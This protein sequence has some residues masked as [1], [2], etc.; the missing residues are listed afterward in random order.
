MQLNI[1][2]GQHSN[3]SVQPLDTINNNPITLP[4]DAT[5]LFTSSDANMLDIVDNADHQTVV[6]SAITAGDVTITAVMTLANGTSFTSTLSVVVAPVVV[7]PQIG[8]IEI[9][10]STPF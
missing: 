9:V 6:A 2:V 8:S 5:V 1:T 4:A 10:A 3:L 7:V